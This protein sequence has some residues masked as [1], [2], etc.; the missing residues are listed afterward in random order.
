MA[1]WM[2]ATT[3]AGCIVSELADVGS[4]TTLGIQNDRM[5]DTTL[6]IYSRL[7]SCYRQHLQ[8]TRATR[9]SREIP[10][11]P[12]PPPLPNTP[13]SCPRAQ[14]PRMV[15][16]N[17]PT[18]TKQLRSPPPQP[19]P[20]RP[21]PVSSPRHPA[22]KPSAPLLST[23]P[24][25]ASTVTVNGAYATFI[26]KDDYL[27]GALV[28]AHCHHMVK[29]KYPFIILATPSL[30]Q[31]ARAIIKKAGI[32]LIDIKSLVPARAQYDPSVTDARFRE[33]WTKLR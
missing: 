20:S 19:S 4:N 28:L 5:L 10:L 31:R 13:P 24:R 33:T 22:P 11:S 1:G 18:P 2:A 8:P 21:L 15:Q 16:A 29:S 26:S 7:A 14:P 17:P 23:P 27:P 12:C 30:S 9:T 6:H 3:R 32:T 25:D